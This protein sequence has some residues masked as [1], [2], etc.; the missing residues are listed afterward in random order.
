MSLQLHKMGFTYP[1]Y[2]NYIEKYVGKQ[3]LENIPLDGLNFW[4]NKHKHIII[5]NMFGG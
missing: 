3:N 2:E 4:V 1:N 5:A